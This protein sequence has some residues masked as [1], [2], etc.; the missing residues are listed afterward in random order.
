MGDLA[1]AYEQYLAFNADFR[2][3]PNFRAGPHFS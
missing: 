1:S 3:A 2:S